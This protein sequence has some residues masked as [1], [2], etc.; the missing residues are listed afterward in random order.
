M[1]KGSKF[2]GDFPFGSELGFLTDAGPV[3]VPEEVF[4]GY[5]FQ[6]GQGWLLHAEFPR[7][8][9]PPE[10]EKSRTKRTMRRQR[11]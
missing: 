2:T 1:N 9:K 6:P 7:R 10:K 3:N 4:H 5:V 8:S 11:G